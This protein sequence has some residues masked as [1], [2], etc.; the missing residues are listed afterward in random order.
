[1]GTFIPVVISDSLFHV[2]CNG[3]DVGYV[4]NFSFCGY[5]E[6]TEIHT[7]VDADMLDVAAKL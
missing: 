6:C 1:M 7:R 2:C 5:S 3:I 4:L